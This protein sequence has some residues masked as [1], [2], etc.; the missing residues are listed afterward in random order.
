MINARAFELAL[1]KNE[2]TRIESLKAACTASHQE[3]LSS[4]KQI[5]G[6]DS[7]QHAGNLSSKQEDDDLRQLLERIEPLLIAGDMAALDLM[8]QLD[9]SNPLLD[10]VRGHLQEYDFEEALALLRAEVER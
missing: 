4:L 9:T 1:K 3:L 5:I 10:K 8:D 6:A 2:E 7:E